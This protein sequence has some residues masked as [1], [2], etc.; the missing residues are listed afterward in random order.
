MD[1]DTDK[2]EILRDLIRA[3]RPPGHRHG[4]AVRDPR[5]VFYRPILSIVDALGGRQQPDSF[6]VFLGR[7]LLG[8]VVRFKWGDWGSWRAADGWGLRVRDT[9]AAA[10]GQLLHLA[11]TTGYQCDRT[12]GTIPCPGTSDR[13][14]RCYIAPLGCEHECECVCGSHW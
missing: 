14:H 9:R 13:V 12:G 8:N 7:H 3:N 5:H 1:S 6:E 11:R 4:P 2:I 10:A